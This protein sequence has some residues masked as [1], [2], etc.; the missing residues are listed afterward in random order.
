MRAMLEGGG[1]VSRSTTLDEDAETQTPDDGG[2][3][4]YMLEIGNGH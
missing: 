3:E 2:R 4:N 1:D